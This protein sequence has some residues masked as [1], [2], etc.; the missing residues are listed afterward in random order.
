MGAVAMVARTRR[1]TRW[2]ATCALI[3]LVGLA[4]G[5]VIAAVAGARRTDSALGRFE[6][7]ALA[8]TFEIDAGNP[9]AAQQRAFAHTP[10]I[11]AVSSL[12]QIA[13]FKPDAGFLPVAGPV[14]GSWGHDV[15]RRRLVR[16]RRAH[17]PLELNHRR[18]P[19]PPPRR[20]RRRPPRVL[21]VHPGADRQRRR[22]RA[23]PWCRRAP[24]SSFRIVGVVRHPLDLGVRGDA[25]GVLVLTRAFVEQYRDQI[26]SFSG[27]ILRVRTTNGERDAERISAAAKSAFGGDEEFRVQPLGIEGGSA[28]N[29][30][31]VAGAALWILAAVLSVAGVVAVG[32]T[33]ARQAWADVDDQPVLRAIGMRRGQ[34]WAATVAL[35]VPIAL[36]GA[37]LAVV[38]AVAASP[39]FPVGVA[40]AAEPDPGLH[41]DGLALLAGFVGV[42]GVVLAAASLAA[43]SMTRRLAERAPRSAFVGR[44]ATSTMLSPAA[45]TGIGFA[46]ERGRGRRAVPVWSSVAIMTMG[47]LGVVAALMFASGLH[48]IS[49]EPPAYGWTWDVSAFGTDHLDDPCPSESVLTDHAG[50]GC[51]DLPVLPRRLGRGERRAALG[52]PPGP[53]RHPADHRRRA[54]APRP[55]TRSH[56]GVTSSTRRV[57]ASAT[58]SEWR[59]KTARRPTGSSGQ[60]VFPS[61]DD[62]LPLAG[63]A[64]ASP[65]GLARAGGAFDNQTV[66]RVRRP[67]S[68]SRPSD[69]WSRTAVLGDRAQVASVPAE[70]ERLRQIDAIPGLLA[71]VT[72]R[73]RLERGRLH[74]R[75]LGAPARARAGGAEDDRLRPG[76]GSQRRWRGRRA[77]SRASASSLAECSVW[78]WAA[79]C[80]ARSRTASGSRP[81]CTSRGSRSRS[82]SPSYS[83]S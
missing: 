41:A 48:H 76:A 70:I 14:D 71:V 15:D 83:S 6:Q 7:S 24:R 38:L 16:G 8:A 33:L 26:G 9:T 82:W 77:R 23:A 51:G 68:T 28:R 19:R 43:W 10:G 81:P 30:A 18:R 80:G 11:E 42:A 40:R 66:V 58:G 64:V 53:G 60:V 45:V 2:P 37:L 5:A 49:T 29:A 73:A 62:P 74:P 13:L 22:S 79:P 69:R 34:R 20:R 31:N 1:R 35:A 50:R 67:A 78:S 52:V 32:F 63:S 4:G 21:L 46:L 39:A 25:G 65:A 12:R 17:G 56:S 36:G 55:R 61:L 54:S 3:A 47:V 27:L 57:S 44:V 59:A 75:A 72:A